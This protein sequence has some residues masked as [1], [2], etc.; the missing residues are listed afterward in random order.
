MPH[1]PTPGSRPAVDGARRPAS[2]VP[3][4]PPRTTRKVAGALPAAP[5]AATPLAEYDRKRDFGRTPE[6]A[7]GD[8]VSA[9]AEPQRP[10]T[11]VV[12]KHAARRLHYDLRLEWDGVMPSWAVPR[13]P[14]V[15]PGDRHL[16]VHVEDHPLSYATFEGVIPRG[17]YGAGQAIVWDAGTYS[18]DEGGV[19]SFHDRAEAEARMREGLVA[20]KLSIQLRGRKLHGS[21]A[22]VR[23][24]KIEAGKE[25][26][27]LL[28]HKDAAA[29]PDLDITAEERSVRSGLTIEELQRGVLPDPEQH[30]TAAQPADLRGAHFA[31]FPANLEPMQA[32]SRLTPFS[33]DRWR[34]EPKL[35]GMRTLAFVRDGQVELRSRRGLDATRRYPGVARALATQPAH[36]LVLDGEIVALDDRGVPSFELLQERLHLSGEEQVARAEAR[37]P[38]I[39]YVF[40]LLYLDGLDFRAVPL[41]DRLETL[42]RVLLPTAAVRLVEEL[43]ADG[44][45]AYHVATSLGLEGVMAKRRDSTYDSGRRSHAWVKVKGR[46]SEEFVVGGYSDGEGGR[47]HTFGA[48]LIGTPDDEGRLVYATHV[49]SGF[50]DRTLAS[51]RDRL[52]AL[53]TPDSPFAEPPPKDGHSAATWVRPEIVVEVAFTQRTRD[54]RLRAPVFLRVRDDKTAAEVTTPVDS[55]DLEPGEVADTVDVT[56]VPH[57][58]AP[59]PT[60]NVAREVEH[61]LAQLETPRKTFTLQ[62]DG[63]E[64][65]VGNLDKELWPA[66]ADAP[67][68]TKRDLLVYYARVAPWLLPHLRDRPLTLTRYPNG[69]DAAFFYQKH[70]ADAPEFVERVQ[71]FSDSGGGDSTYLLCNNLATLLWLG[72]MADLALHTTLARVNPQPDG[73]HLAT[74]FSG[75]KEQIEASLLNYP[76]FLLFDLDPYTYAGT[77]AKGAEPEL[78]R[79]A[80]E[81]TC[82]VARW[83]KTLLDGASLASYVKTSGAT[84]LHIYVPVLRDYDYG[85]LRSLC[86]TFAEFLRREH[87][88]D[89]TTDW[90]IEKRTG[91]VFL[92]HNQNARIKNLAAPYSPRAKP[93]APVSMPLRWDEVGTVYASDFTIR[94]APARL[95][96][97]GDVWADILANKQDL[98]ALIEGPSAD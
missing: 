52:E 46:A 27:L 44:E 38:V 55:A 59:A 97:H 36:T 4:R 17:A 87:P 47:A 18:P 49:G 7:G 89:V 90:T 37:I 76:D 93:G 50:D 5:A 69:I 10:L 19:L 53:R 94:N 83:L 45:T 22:L 21:W 48:L 96:R 9:P 16:A 39:Y 74:T 1:A 58:A 80:W 63:H 56:P 68:T 62:V 82:R 20:G 26:W 79:E 57:A 60:S 29:N 92:D 3:G 67:A 28:K 61:V 11:F 8:P 30:V 25:Q 84:G 85:E 81:Q 64:L 34:F 70:V 54:G 41:Q 6:P 35:D 75:S 78:N 23:T 13:G 86:G 15:R 91:K 88:K 73:H 42:A 33:D 43:P 14:S 2:A 40:D 66:T 98:R 32:E 12:H 95:A 77:E 71:V 51:L 31:P 65:R 72:Q 24:A